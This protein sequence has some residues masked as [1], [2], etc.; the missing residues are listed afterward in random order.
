MIPFSV[1]IFAKE[2]VSILIKNG[3]VLTMNKAKTVYNNGVIAILNDKIVAIGEQELLDKYIADKTIDADNGI[4]I[5]GMINTHS[6]LPMIAFRGLGEQGIKNRL[7][8]YVFPL[9]HEKL[10]R[11]LIYKA[12]IHGS[13]ELAMGGV[14]T[15]ADMYY[16]MDEMA[17]AT[18]EIGLRAVLGE[19]IIN[20]PVVDAKEPYGGLEYG[21]SFIKEYKN[22]KLITPAL[23]P[24]APYSVSKSKLMEIKKLADQYNSPIMIHCSEYDDEPK[25]IGDN[26]GLDSPIKYLDSIGILD[27]KMLLAHCIHITDEDI[28]IVKRTKVG[29]SYNPLSNA[30]GAHGIARI[31]E[32]KEQGIT[33]IGLGTDGPMSSN[34]VDL[35]RVLSYSCIMQRIKY[36]NSAIMTPEVVFEMATIGGA[37]A[38]NMDDKI[39][40][41]E[42]GKL[43]DIVIIETKSINMIPNY[44]PYAT[45]VFQGNPSNVETTIVNGKIIVENKKIKTYSMETNLKN[46]KEITT[47][48][49]EFAKDLDKKTKESNNLI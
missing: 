2:K 48:I 4:V 16:H 36:N 40:S 27:E 47:D 25:K 24:H 46:M 43:A 20:F 33:K 39:G 28:E 37:R 42:S 13:I 9:E 5:P 7:F 18:K 23:A 31:D 21:I 49:K 29:I 32:M 6:H 14:T 26:I 3:Q 11:E 10:S 22:D 12:A 19:T 17:K 45:I 15:Y 44:D 30:K 1:G 38:L 41:L 35:F 34:T 8:N